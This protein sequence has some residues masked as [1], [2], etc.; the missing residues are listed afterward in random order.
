MQITFLSNYPTKA[1]INKESIEYIV[2]SIELRKTK[3]K[4]MEKK[5]KE[6]I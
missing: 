5:A 3:E 6:K 4:R 2:S 1:Y